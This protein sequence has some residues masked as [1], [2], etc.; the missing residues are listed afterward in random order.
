[1]NAHT[2]WILLP[3]YIYYTYIS[4]WWYT[5]H[6]CNA[7]ASVSIKRC[8][9]RNHWAHKQKCLYERRLKTLSCHFSIDFVHFDTV[10]DSICFGT[11]EIN[12]PAAILLKQTVNFAAAAAALNHF[13]LSHFH[14]SFA[15]LNCVISWPF[16]NSNPFPIAKFERNICH[17]EFECCFTSA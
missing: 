12:F 17:I 16:E 5:L 14:P 15:G 11:N 3:Y 1:M 2:P 13:H 10:V 4:R 7:Y 8:S 9:L 6:T